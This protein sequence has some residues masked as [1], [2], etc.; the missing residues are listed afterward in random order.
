MKHIITKIVSEN[1]GNYLLQFQA[2]WG[3]GSFT[4]VSWVNII[5]VPHSYKLLLRFVLFWLNLTQELARIKFSG[6]PHHWHCMRVASIAIYNIQCQI[7]S[8]LHL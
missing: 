1:A 8:F 7:L 3:F 6:D 4:L 2:I 5:G